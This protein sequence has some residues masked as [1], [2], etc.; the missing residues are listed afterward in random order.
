M[1]SMQ[2]CKDPRQKVGESSIRLA[3]E[4]SPVILLTLIINVDLCSCLEAFNG[5]WGS[6]GGD[7]KEKEKKNHL[8]AINLEDANADYLN[9]NGSGECLGLLILTELVIDELIEKKTAVSWK[10]V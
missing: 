10:K 2:H 6:K 3:F 7:K 1:P 5:L 9:S 4:C 8:L